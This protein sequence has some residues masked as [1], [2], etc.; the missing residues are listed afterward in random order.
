MT[1]LGDELGRIADDMP[2]RDLAVRAI[3]V[4]HRRRRNLIALAAAALVVV[5]VLGGT[6]AIKLT[7]KAARPVAPPERTVIDVG[8]AGTAEAAPLY[9]ALSKGYFAAEGLTVRPAVVHAAAAVSAMERGELD[10][11]QTDYVVSFVANQQNRG[12]KIV[13]GLHRAHTGTLA[14]VVKAGSG[15]RTV[16]DLKG[17]KI[18]VPYLRGLGTLSIRAMGLRNDD[19]EFVETPYTAMVDGLSGGRF[20]AALLAEPYV[21]VSV[22]QGRTRVLREALARE[23]DRLPT[24]G[25]MAADDWIKANPRTLAAFRRALAKAQRLIAGDLAQAVRAVQVIP[26]DMKVAWR[27]LNRLALG[28]FPAELDLRGLQRLADLA[29]RYSVLKKR[30]DVRSVIR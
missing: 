4:Y 18:A 10:I 27:D 23:F 12:V 26:P 22:R 20:A 6:A 13:G 1:W 16:A 3:E 11:A 17:K 30:L 28:A 9:V 2:Q 19:V 7:P 25:W 5:V 8:V 24:A 15:I 29:L 14:L 21:V